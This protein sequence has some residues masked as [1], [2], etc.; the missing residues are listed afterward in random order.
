VRQL[1]PLVGRDDDFARLGDVVGLPDGP[2][3]RVLISGDAGVGKTR[4]VSETAARAEQAGWRV[5]VGHCLDLGD[6]GLPYLPFR[7]A[8]GRLPIDEPAL[9]D[10]PRAIRRLLPE[11]A[12]DVDDAAFR[13]ETLERGNCSRPCP[14]PCDGLPTGRRS[15]W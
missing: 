15:C 12:S 9:L 10:A 7:E 6:G 5:L 13:S 1:A 14:R 3:G 4:L 11:R 8:L 2:A